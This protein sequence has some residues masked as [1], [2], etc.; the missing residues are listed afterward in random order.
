MGKR[1]LIIDDERDM[2]LYLATLFRKAGYDTIIAEN[3]DQ[4]VSMAVEEQP[5]LI[6]LDLLMPRQSGVMAYRRLRD[7]PETAAIPVVILTGLS[8]QDDL[9]RSTAA[10]LPEP[11]AVVEKPIDRER[12]LRTVGG[13]I[14]PP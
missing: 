1:I 13:I 9:F 2:Q 6:T 5:D 7:A 10:G 11:E 4:G 3:G 14:G 8:R 12:F